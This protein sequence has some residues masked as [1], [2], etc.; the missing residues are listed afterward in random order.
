M[1]NKDGTGPQGQGPKTGRLRGGCAAGHK[2]IIK[3]PALGKNPG[4]GGRNGP[5]GAGAGRDFAVQLAT[6]N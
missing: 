4:N 1:P 2:N 6:P 3:K 5:G